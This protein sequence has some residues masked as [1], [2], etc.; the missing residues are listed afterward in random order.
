MKKFIIY[1]LSLLLPC[2]ASAQAQINTKKVKI[3]DFTDKTTKVVLTG[4]M[5]HD[6]QLEKAIKERW[7]ISA[8]EF[9]TMDE[10]NN[11]VSDDNYYFLLT[12]SG[13]FAKEKEPGL[14]FLTLVKGGVDNSKNINNMLEVVSFPFA[15]TQNPSGREYVFLPAILD[16][17]QNH[18]TNS[19]EKDVNGYIGLPNYS[20][21]ITK[22]GNMNLVFSVDDLSSEVT[23]ELQRVYFDGKVLVVEESDAD[24]YMAPETTNTLV[25]YVVTPA[26]AKPGSY[27]YKMLF[28]PQSSTLYYFRKH[29]IS[30]KFGPGFLAEDIKR[31]CTPRKK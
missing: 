22:S 11:L 21:N 17:I 26:D 7:H 6:A 2:L 13:Q 23:Q 16:M 1:T 15:S 24:D 10:Y 30:N 14:T 20:L 28:D 18:V 8:T 27:C 12:V 19:I 4:K 31:I 29:K 25:S 5:Y 9:C 3:S